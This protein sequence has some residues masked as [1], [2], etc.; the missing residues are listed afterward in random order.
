MFNFNNQNKRKFDSNLQSSHQ[1]ISKQSNYD[2]SF[3][4]PIDQLLGL[5]Y[6][7]N[8]F[9]KKIFFFFFLLSIPF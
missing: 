1:K 7:L 2:E 8:F 6:I 4:T 9:I 3:P 5:F